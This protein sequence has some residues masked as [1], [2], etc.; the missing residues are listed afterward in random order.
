MKTPKEIRDNLG[1]TL[2]AHCLYKLIEPL[3]VSA[4]NL[5]YSDACNIYQECI[6][7]KGLREVWDD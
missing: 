1:S 4:Y 3:I 5:G 7:K 2:I 6:D